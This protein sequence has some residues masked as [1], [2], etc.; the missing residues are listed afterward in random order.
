MARVRSTAR[1]TAGDEAT[2][3]IETT[4]IL[5]VMS[6]SGIVK[7]KDAEEADIVEKSDSEVEA[8]NDTDSDN[9]EDPNILH[10]SKP[11]HIELDKSTIKTKDLDVL[12]R[13]GAKG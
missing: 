7:P 13:H 11:S 4:P 3:M 5:E 9:D 10:P 12:K 6:E 1:L 8:E 2:D